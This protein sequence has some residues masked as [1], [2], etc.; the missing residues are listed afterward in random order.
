MVAGPGSVSRTHGGAL[1]AVWSQCGLCGVWSQSKALCLL[2]CSCSM[3]LDSVLSSSPLPSSSQRQTLHFI[4]MFFAFIRGRYPPNYPFLAPENMHHTLQ[5]AHMA[6]LWRGIGQPFLH[7]LF[8]M[9][10]HCA[11]TVHANSVHRD[12]VHIVCMP[13]SSGEQVVSGSL[14][15][16]LLTI[17]GRAV[18]C[19][20]AHMKTCAVQV[21]V[22]EL[23]HTIVPN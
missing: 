17:R 19:R 7:G 16:L 10:T 11:H 9:C 23:L 22:C 4:N 3:L 18:P 6:Q 14:A 5:I 13:V 8:A 2:T 21:F 20:L 12:S 1:C 15:Q